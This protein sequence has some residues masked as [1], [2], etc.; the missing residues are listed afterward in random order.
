MGC[1]VTGIA[2]VTTRHEGVDFGMTCNSFNTVSLDPAL[3]L[4]SVQHNASSYEAFTRSGGYSVSIL[5]ADQEKLVRRFTHGPQEERFA[6][7]PVTRLDS[8]RLVSTARLHG[9]IVR[10]RKPFL[11]ATTT[12]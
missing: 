3:V 4:W 11:P 7:L 12:C 6:G 1:F 10:W 2:V 8:G 9:S 5:G